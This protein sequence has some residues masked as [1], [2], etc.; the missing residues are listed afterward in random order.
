MQA[1]STAGWLKIDWS[2]N[3]VPSVVCLRASDVYSLV[4]VPLFLA[5]AS[6]TAA[7]SRLLGH[8]YNYLDLLNE[9]VPSPAHDSR[10]FLGEELSLSIEFVGEGLVGLR[11][12][13]FPFYLVMDCNAL[14]TRNY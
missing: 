6:L 11:L 3:S 4:V 13:P 12:Q 5:V 9:L 2:I 7:S 14:T 8:S 10:V 1:T